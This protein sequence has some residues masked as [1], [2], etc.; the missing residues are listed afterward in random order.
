VGWGSSASTIVCR[1]PGEG[2]KLGEDAAKLE[3]GNDGAA[4]DRVKTDGAKGRDETVVGGWK[5]D[6]PRSEVELDGAAL[7]KTP[8]SEGVGRVRVK[9]TSVEDLET[10]GTER[11]KKED[12]DIG[13]MGAKEAEAGAEIKAAEVDGGATNEPAFTVCSLSI[14]SSS[15]AS[16]YSSMSVSLL[17][18]ESP[19][20]SLIVSL[21]ESIESCTRKR[22]AR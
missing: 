7:E 8:K 19:S 10:V 22:M 14:G 15:K 6:G 2:A 16:L 18:E 13:W 1:T 3:S 9:D 4:A 5:T 20:V 12:A 11:V 21:I 17:S